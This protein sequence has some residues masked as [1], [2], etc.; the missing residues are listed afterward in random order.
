M[1]LVRTLVLGRPDGIRARLRRMLLGRQPPAPPSG[2][3]VPE[4]GERSLNLGI[5]PP[6]DVTPPEGFEVVLHRDAL[7]P[8]QVTEVIIGG[9]AL[10]LANVDG[11]FHALSNVCPHAQGPLGEGT[12]EGT[13]LRC[14][15]HGWTFDVTTG[16]CRTTPGVEVPTYRVQVVDDAVC[17]EL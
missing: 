1:G 16:A 15:Y 17:V 6:R 12:L 7:P 3:S 14:P 11:T 8:G 4:P 9:R 10:A 13:L 2:E 5:E